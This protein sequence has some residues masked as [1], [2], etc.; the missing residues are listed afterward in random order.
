MY[1]FSFTGPQ[2]MEV[3]AKKQHN[4]VCTDF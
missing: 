1:K 3:D 4:A 2:A